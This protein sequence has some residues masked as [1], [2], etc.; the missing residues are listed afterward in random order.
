M[1]TMQW[2]LHQPA[3]PPCVWHRWSHPLSDSAAV[4]SL[5]I[6][7]GLGGNARSAPAA[8]GGPPRRSPPSLLSSLT[9]ARVRGHRAARSS[10]PAHRGSL[11]AQEARSEEKGKPRKAGKGLM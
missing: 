4:T 6:T 9:G 1:G 2:R 10:V 8:T 7:A 5:Q 3:Q 11:G